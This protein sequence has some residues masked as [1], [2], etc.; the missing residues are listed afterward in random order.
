MVAGAWFIAV[1]FGGGAASC[2]SQMFTIRRQRRRHR[3]CLPQR[4]RHRGRHG[5]EATGRHGCDASAGTDPMPRQARSDASSRTFGPDEALCCDDQELSTDAA[6]RIAF[7]PWLRTLVHMTDQVAA[8][9][10][11]EVT[12]RQAG[13]FSRRQA[14][15]AGFSPWQVRGYPVTPPA[16]TVYSSYD[17]LNRDRKRDRLLATLGWT[18]LRFTAD[19]VRRSPHAMVRE[20]KDHIA[21]IDRAA[22]RSA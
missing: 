12:R 13:I 8:K 22:G 5:S 1:E 20:I 2:W 4:R 18:V 10:L 9:R 14:L 7:P 16:R 19:D 21:R 11:A 3:W 15:A 6:R 17:A